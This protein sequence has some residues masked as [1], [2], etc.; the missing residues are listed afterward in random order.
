M[1]ALI[2]KGIKSIKNSH[3][4]SILLKWQKYFLYNSHK[5]SFWV[6]L[7]KENTF[8]NVLM[9]IYCNVF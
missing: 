1:M 4:N 8:T 9:E 3:F 2:I 5:E 6:S 7:Q